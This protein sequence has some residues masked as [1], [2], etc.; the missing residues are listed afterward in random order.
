[1]FRE[2]II[3]ILTLQKIPGIGIKTVNKILS[4]YDSYSFKASTPK[5]VIEILKAERVTLRSEKAV[6]QAWKEAEKILRKSLEEH[7]VII[8]IKDSNYPKALSLIPDPPPLIHVRG[9]THVFSRDGIAIVGTRE[10]SEEGRKKATELGRLFAEKGYVIVS[11]LAR[12]IDTAAHQGALEA[13]AGL[14]VAVLAHGLHTIYPKDNKDLADKIVENGGAL[15][16]EHPW[17]ARPQRFEFV[18]RDRIQSGLSLGVIVV[19][20]GVKGG[21]MH[22]ARFCKN[23]NRVLIVWEHPIRNHPKAEG[24]YKL[25]EDKMADVILKENN[26]EE[27]VEKLDVVRRRLALHD[28]RIP[29][30]E[31]KDVINHKK[32]EKKGNRRRR[33]TTKFPQIS[34]FDDKER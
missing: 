31:G 11:G 17:G 18:R 8:S 2:H 33:N 13:D 20:T 34:L 23:Q 9:D 27:I 5:D 3:A 12:G 25:I 15:V 21:T 26:I 16:S 30:D 1:M 10:P 24:N 29:K 14:T 22:T 7:I 6:F 32:K 28:K 19:E 4:K